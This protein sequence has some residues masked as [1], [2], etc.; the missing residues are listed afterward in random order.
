V[1]FLGTF[2]AGGLKTSVAGGKLIIEKEGRARKFV[3]SVEHRS[4]S[5]RYSTMKGQTALYITERC[6]FKLTENGLELSEV[7]PGVDLE[8]D[9]LAHMDFSPEITDH[10]RLMDERIFRTE[11]M[12][13]K[14]ELLGLSLEERLT[15]NPDE[16]L[17]FVNFEGYSVRS[18]TDIEAIKA[19][20]EQAL[21]PLNRKVYCIVNYDNFTILPDLVDDYSKMVREVVDRFYSGVTRYTTSAFLRMKLGDALEQRNL[22]PHIYES[23]EEARE[24]L[25]RV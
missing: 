18:V 12:G 14:D 20:V 21:T 10:P 19:M 2:T 16:D 3:S 15:Y 22:S 11:P 8:K 1:V 9:V 13:L 17:F 24:V 6:V 25:N 23:R 7:A 5:G 4:F